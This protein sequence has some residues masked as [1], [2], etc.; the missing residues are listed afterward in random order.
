VEGNPDF[1][2]ELI[3]AGSN[4]NNFVNIVSNIIIAKDPE[5]GYT[6][7]QIERLRKIEKLTLTNW[8]RI[9]KFLSI[10]YIMLLLQN[11]V[12]IRE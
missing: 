7:L 12:I 10:I 11:K 1:Y 2:E 8:R 3:R 6:S 5:L 9:K 4:T